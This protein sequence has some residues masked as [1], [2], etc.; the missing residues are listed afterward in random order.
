MTE[1]AG[2]IEKVGDEECMG[3]AEHI[4]HSGERE[5]EN[6][7]VEEMLCVKPAEQDTCL[8]G[9]SKI[10]PRDAASQKRLQNRINRIVGQLNGIGNMI[11]ENRYCG[12]ILIQIGA[13]ERALQSLGYIILQEHMQSCV[14]EEVKNGNEAI[15]EETIELIKKLK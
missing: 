4:E 13:V 8:C 7:D 5:V 14:V 1:K 3:M 12:D 9:H 6:V 10:V 11:G 2:F 15:M